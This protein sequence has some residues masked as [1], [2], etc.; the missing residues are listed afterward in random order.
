M[1]LAFL[2]GRIL[3]G[4]VF[5]MFGI[6]HFKN[7]KGMIEYIKSK[8]VASPA[9]ANV[10]AG[11]MLLFSGIL[12]VLG[13][14]PDIALFVL[15]LFLIVVSVVMHDFWNVKGTEEE[16][17]TQMIFFMMNMAL[18]GA[19]IMLIWLSYWPMSL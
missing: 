19:S 17:R 3:F 15:I 4:G 16:K 14:F 1:E 5:L 9:L 2:I 11:V 10:V 12:L 8:N 6:M 18:I 13:I 7:R